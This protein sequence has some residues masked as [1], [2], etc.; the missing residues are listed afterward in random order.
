MMPRSRIRFKMFQHFVVRENF[1]EKKVLMEKNVDEKIF[2]VP[3]ERTN[4]IQ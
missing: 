1:G 2:K 4:E 3:T